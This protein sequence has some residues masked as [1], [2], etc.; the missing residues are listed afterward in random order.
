MLL[1]DAAELGIGRL[2]VMIG[3]YSSEGI[4]GTSA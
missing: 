1:I 4:G 3:E 2:L